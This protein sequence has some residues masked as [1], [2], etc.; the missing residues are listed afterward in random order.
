MPIINSARN[1]V[2]LL[3]MV[4]EEGE[5]LSVSDVAKRAKRFGLTKATVRN[6]LDTLAFEGLL[7]KHVV[8]GG[9]AR[10][11]LGFNAARLWRQ[12]IC[13]G[14]ESAKAK[15]REAEREMHAVQ[16]LENFGGERLVNRNTEG[17]P[18]IEKEQ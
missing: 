7:Q 4:G 10:F 3:E 8:P 5:P 13:A 9:E 15:H 1:A 6:L 12:Y 18:S 16:E 2:R 11:A 14:I 17:W